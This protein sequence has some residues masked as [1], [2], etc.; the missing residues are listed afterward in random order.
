M[1][2]FCSKARASGRAF[3][4]RTVSGVGGRGRER[5][6]H[7]R[8]HPRGGPARPTPAPVTPAFLSDGGSVLHLLGNPAAAYRGPGLGEDGHEPPQGAGLT[9]GTGLRGAWRRR[10]WL[11]TFA[12]RE[13]TLIEREVFGGG[14]RAVWGWRP[15]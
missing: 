6:G 10:R 7:E 4:P 9:P 2:V 14:I 12:N 13:K 3:L 11:A 5:P 1:R 15:I 8:G